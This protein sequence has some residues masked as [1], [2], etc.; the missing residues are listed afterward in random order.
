MSSVADQLA[1]SPIERWV[2]QVKFVD[3]DATSDLGQ[4]SEAKFYNAR[5]FSELVDRTK[6]AKRSKPSYNWQADEH[7]RWWRIWFIE[8][9]LTIQIDSHSSNG[10]SQRNMYEIDLERCTTAASFVECLYSAILGK[11]W[12]SPEM[13]WAV[14]EVADEAS[15]KRFK[16]PLSRTFSNNRE[17]D[18]ANPN[19]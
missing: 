2:K 7:E 16:K 3:S 14:M 9:N 1:N 13:L 17:L 10:D 6:L 15:R 19:L 8:S 12:A 5:E 4:E 18:W 11:T